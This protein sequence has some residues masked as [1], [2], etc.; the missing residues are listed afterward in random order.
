MILFLVFLVRYLALL[1]FPWVTQIWNMEAIIKAYVNQLNVRS[2]FR[3]LWEERVKRLMFPLKT[4][5]ML[6]FFHHLRF[7]CKHCFCFSPAIVL[8]CFI[9][10][11]GLRMWWQEGSVPQNLWPVT[12]Q[13]MKTYRMEHIQ[14][15]KSFFFIKIKIETNEKNS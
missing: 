6:S 4:S 7:A 12:W 15:L 10:I 1:L 2:F 5:P 14:S 3:T 8:C 11:M 13:V 9:C